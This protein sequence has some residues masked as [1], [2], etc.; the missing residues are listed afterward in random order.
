MASTFVA[1]SDGHGGTS[2]MEATAN[3]SPAAANS[4]NLLAPGLHP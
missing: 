4:T 2:V 3:Q 1:S